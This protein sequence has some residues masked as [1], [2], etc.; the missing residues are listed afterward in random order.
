MPEEFRVDKGVLGEGRI[1]HNGNLIVRGILTRT[2]VF[3]YRHTDKNGKAYS[4]RELRHPDDV[5]D[6]EAVSSFAQLPVTDDHPTDGQITPDNVKRFSVGN[7]GDS[8]SREGPTENHVAADL[9]IRHKDAIN[10]ALGKEN[11]PP[12]RFLSCGY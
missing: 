5:Y 7:L 6:V 4:T 11:Q 12:K 3:T 9:I 2:G 1:D 8:L 10:K